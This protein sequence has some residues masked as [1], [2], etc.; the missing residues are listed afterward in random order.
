MPSQISAVQPTIVSSNSLPTDIEDVQFEI[1]LWLSGLESFLN[2][3]NHSFIDRERPKADHDWAKEARLVHSA[4]LL[5]TKLTSRLLERSP[6]S[7]TTGQASREEYIAIDEIRILSTGLRDSIL[8]SEA[9]VRAEPLDFGIWKAWSNTLSEKLRGY[10]ANQKFIRQAEFLG[11]HYLPPKLIKLIDENPMP[12]AEEADLKQILP[13]FAKVL[14]WLSVVARMLENDE[15]LKPALLVFARVNEQTRELIDHINN[16]LSRFPDEE[17]E[18]FGSLDGAS[19]TAAIEVR[20]VYEQ[21]LSGIVSVR[22]SLSIYARME[23]AYSLLNDSFEQILTGFARLIDPKVEVADLFPNFGIKLQRSLRLRKDLWSL[24]KVVQSAE[25]D[26]TE[27]A[28]RD[29]QKRQSEFLEES[30][31]FLFYKD[32]ESIER[33]AEALAVTVDGKDLVGT[34]HRYGTYLETLFGQVNMRTALVDHP[35]DPNK[36]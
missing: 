24:M 22:P 25:K 10:R 16:R 31:H 32:K 27:K 36:L 30:V 29:M 34:L 11:E 7:L 6:G 33:F 17:A 23:T 19:Y 28:I 5:C 18:L 35:F 26:A 13:R 3:G 4:L 15:P 1:G 12:F 21:E 8:I 9:L 20:K 14:K 2:A